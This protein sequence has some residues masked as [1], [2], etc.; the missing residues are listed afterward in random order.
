[1]NSA[2]HL[3]NLIEDALDM[4]RIENNKFE[5]NNEEFE[6]RKVIKEI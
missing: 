6:I 2:Y 4:S 3:S 1:M 5:I